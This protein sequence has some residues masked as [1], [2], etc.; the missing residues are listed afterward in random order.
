MPF[1]P[2]TYMLALALCFKIPIALSSPTTKHHLQYKKPPENIKASSR[3]HQ[4]TQQTNQAEMLN[5]AYKE[6]G[7]KK[8]KDYSSLLTEKTLQ[9]K[10]KLSS[11]DLEPHCTIDECEG[12]PGSNNNRTLVSICEE[13]QAYD[14]DNS[15]INFAMNQIANNF[16]QNLTKVS[17]KVATHPVP[18]FRRWGGNA[19]RYGAFGTPKPLSKEEFRRTVSVKEGWN[20]AEH[21]SKLYIKKG[22]VFIMGPASAKWD[23]TSASPQALSGGGIQILNLMRSCLSANYP[24]ALKLPNK[25][26]KL[27]YH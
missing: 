15:T 8:I 24:K 10:P 13:L 19:K 4:E 12:A 20:T 23:D 26:T 22:G 18:F 21:E 7:I 11:S 14:I 16:S 9:K 5:E 2:P 25:K 6:R 17:V 3:K 1:L 27:T